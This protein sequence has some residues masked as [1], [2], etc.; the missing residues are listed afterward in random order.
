M[1]K[2]LVLYICTGKYD[3]FW[4]GFYDSSEKFFLKNCQKDYFVFTDAERI[5]QEE[6]DNVHKIY[7]ENLGWPGNTL[8]RYK[9]FLTHKDILLK[10]D[11]IFFINANM[12]F[13]SVVDESIL[14]ESGL[15]VVQHPGY[16]NAERSKLPYDRNP[17]SMAYISKNEGKVYVCGGFNGGTSE[18]FLMMTETINNNTDKDFSRDIVAKWHDESHIN[19]YIL[20]H[21]Y[22][23][24]SPSYAYPED[25]RLPFKCIVM[26]RDK[27]KYG[28]H[29]FL[30]NVKESKLNVVA[31]KG[32][33]LLRLLM[34]G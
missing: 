21:P 32:K 33:R 31:R 8:F 25:S 17:Q 10:Y 34:G 24:L 15:I 16:Y 28:G 30:R 11:Y 12:E 4:K 13:K 3:V 26:I 6:S 27:E 19:K 5:Y 1:Y 7:Q 14:P 22:H 9:I 18:A 23:L 20:N 29:A 2:V